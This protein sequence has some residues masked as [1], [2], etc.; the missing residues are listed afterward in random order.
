MAPWK[1]RSL[2]ESIIFRVYVNFWGC[3]VSYEP[4]FICNPRTP[5]LS[6]SGW[7]WHVRNAPLLQKSRLNHLETSWKVDSNMLKNQ[8]N[9]NH[10]SKNQPRHDYINVCGQHILPRKVPKSFAFHAGTKENSK[11]LERWAVTIFRFFFPQK[12]GTAKTLSSAVRWYCLRSPCSPDSRSGS[13]PPAA[14][15]DVW[16]MWLW[17]LPAAANAGNRMR[18]CPPQVSAPGPENLEGIHEIL[19]CGLPEKPTNRGWGIWN[20]NPPVSSASGYS[21]S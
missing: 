8:S 5:G 2:L 17:Q 6:S 14:S 10:M 11:Q 16:P 4:F 12:N 20:C 7:L 19:Q 9:C 21:K 3:I 15:Q 18:R 13:S 1:R